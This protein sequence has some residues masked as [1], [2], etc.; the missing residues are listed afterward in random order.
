MSASLAA[1]AVCAC[2]ANVAVRRRGTHCVRRPS[3]YVAEVLKTRCE[4][5]KRTR[6]ERFI[7]TARSECLDWMIPLNER[8]LPRVLVEWIPHYNNE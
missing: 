3:F 1:T 8:H 6:S 4:P 2:W 7:G 5:R